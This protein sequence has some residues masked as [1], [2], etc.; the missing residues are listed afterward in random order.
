MDPDPTRS[1]QQQN[2]AAPAYDISVGG[3]YGTLPHIAIVF[4][5]RGACGSLIDT[6]G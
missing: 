4:A 6:A 1:G 5:D 3:H 2:A